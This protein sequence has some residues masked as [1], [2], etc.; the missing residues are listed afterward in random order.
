MTNHKNIYERARSIRLAQ[1][2]ALNVK[3][4]P[5]TFKTEAERIRESTVEDIARW[6][7]SSG[8]NGYADAQNAMIV[9][10]RNAVGAA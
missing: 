9:A 6:G 1:L 10:A 4:E 5:R 2:D 8:Q 7:L 3:N